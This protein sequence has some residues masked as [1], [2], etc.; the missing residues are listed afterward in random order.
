MLYAHLLHITGKQLSQLVQQVR[1][2]WSI[3]MAPILYFQDT[4]AQEFDKHRAS[5][6]RP[7]VS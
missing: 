3:Q 2:E 6:Y 5:I 1:E 4:R 7:E